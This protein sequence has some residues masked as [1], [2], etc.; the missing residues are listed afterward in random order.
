MPII[1]VH[2]LEGRTVNQKRKMVDEVT[3]ALVRSFDVK[4]ESVRILIH[5]MVPENY[6][7]A[8]ITAGEQPLRSRTRKTAEVEA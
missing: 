4:P 5:E 1:H 2:I 7:L 8:G 6:A 3:Q